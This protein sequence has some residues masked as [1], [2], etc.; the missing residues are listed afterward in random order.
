MALEVLQELDGT[1][2]RIIPATYCIRRLY[3]KGI[4]ERI[5][6]D[7]RMVFVLNYN[8]D[9]VRIPLGGVYRYLSRG[10]R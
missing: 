5:G 8:E 2:V 3:T 1:T 4:V 6:S 10:E 9:T 7:N